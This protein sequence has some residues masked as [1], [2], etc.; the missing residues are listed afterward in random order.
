TLANR[1][2]RNNGSWRVEFPFPS[3]SC[4][5]C[6]HCK[7]D[8][9]RMWKTQGYRAVFVGNGVTDRCGAREASLTFA[10]DEL[11]NWCDSQG[12]E[13]IL[14]QSFTEVQQ[15]LQQRGWL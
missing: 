4:Q 14:F 8:P 6:G 12:I 2:T 5:A 1:L 11:K 15:E 7:A 9:I 10:K 3:T 13:A